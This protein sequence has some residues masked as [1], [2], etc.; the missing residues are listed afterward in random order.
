MLTEMAEH[1]FAPSLLIQDKMIVNC[2]PPNPVFGLSHERCSD[3]KKNTSFF[4]FDSP[5]VFPKRVVYNNGYHGPGNQVKKLRLI[6]RFH[7]G[8]MF[9]DN[10]HYF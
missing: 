3:E 2:F 4:R 9:L 10:C 5:M 1:L 6:V 8:E 7:Y